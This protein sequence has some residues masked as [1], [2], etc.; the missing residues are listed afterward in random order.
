LKNALAYYSDGV[1]V[2]NFEV[3]GLASG[4]ACKT[5]FHPDFELQ[6]F[7]KRLPGLGANPGSFGFSF[8][9]SSLFRRAT[10]APLYNELLASSKTE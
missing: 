5:L 9:S 10:A 4:F 8:I 7:F 3:V 6:Q 1:V 2:V